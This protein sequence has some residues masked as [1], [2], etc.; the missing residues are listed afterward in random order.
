LGLIR[1]VAGWQHYKR[2]MIIYPRHF[3]RFIDGRA[4]RQIAIAFLPGELGRHLG[5]LETNVMLR[6]DYAHK[7][8]RHD[9]Y[10][11][12]FG[13]IQNTIDNGMCMRE[14]P[15][16]LAFLYVKDNISPEIYFLVIKT[17][18]AKNELWLKTFYR[19]R[20]AQYAKKLRPYS[21]LRAH[22]ENEFMG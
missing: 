2:S 9:I 4:G 8:I 22:A 19:I 10:Y 16:E 15:N 7:L 13:E 5:T 6:L 12:G 3:V 21:I 17:P 18:Y 11:E 20:K 1:R 14:G